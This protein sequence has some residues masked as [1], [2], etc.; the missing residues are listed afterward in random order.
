M[1]ASPDGQQGQFGRSD[2]LVV[3]LKSGTPDNFQ[4]DGHADGLPA[5]V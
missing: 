1:S 2:G 5:N 4:N 3:I